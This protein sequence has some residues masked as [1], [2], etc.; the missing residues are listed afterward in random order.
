MDK[1]LKEF[2]KMQGTDTMNAMVVN[3]LIKNYTLENV[4]F[5]ELSPNDKIP[6]DRFIEELDLQK[7]NPYSF[8]DIIGGSYITMDGRV[9]NRAEDEFIMECFL[10]QIQNVFM[11]AQCSIAFGKDD[12]WF[13]K[14][15]MNL[16]PL[17]KQIIKTDVE[18]K[19]SELTPVFKDRKDE[20]ACYDGIAKFLI[21]IKA[22][23]LRQGS[24]VDR[25][26][27][28]LPYIPYFVQ[29]LLKQNKNRYLLANSDTDSLD[30]KLAILSAIHFMNW[31]HTKLF[32]QKA[33]K[34]ESTNH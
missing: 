34:W 25:Y 9:A 17:F 11:S 26:V 8:S 3:V 19:P 28:D 10:F 30:Y 20:T 18:V 33:Q 7:F 13:S 6:F 15:I 22:R 12:F 27:K 14:F 24:C 29:R 31:D 21:S 4:A 16:Y 32:E 23:S 2:E 1:R 5:G